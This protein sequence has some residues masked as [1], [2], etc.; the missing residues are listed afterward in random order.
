MNVKRA[1]FEEVNKAQLELLFD[2]IQKAIDTNDYIDPKSRSDYFDRLAFAFVG[3]ISEYDF[4]FKYKGDEYN[5]G[6]LSFYARK[7]AF[8]NEKTP[9]IELKGRKIRVPI[10][11]LWES[12]RENLYKPMDEAL[13]LA[14][15]SSAEIL[16]GGGG[17]H[18]I[19]PDRKKERGKD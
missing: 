16:G 7:M 19:N 13:T 4:I 10:K 1:T 18:S 3:K 12:L 8:F 17:S 6:K 2:I 15:R 11:E 5:L 9:E 14:L